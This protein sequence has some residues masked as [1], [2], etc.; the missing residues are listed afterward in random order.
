MWRWVTIGA[1]VCLAT[2]SACGEA[3]RQPPSA[4]PTAG[5]AGASSG[6]GAGSGNTGGSASAEPIPL[7]D[8]CG[9]FTRDLCVYLMECQGARYRDAAHCERELDCFGL[10]QLTAAADSGAVEYDPSKVGA[11]HARFLE[12]PCTFG[13]FLFTPDIYEVLSYC[14]GTI[15]PKLQAGEACSSNGECSTGLYCYKGVDYQCPGTCRLP[16]TEG[17][18]CA[19]SGRCADG[20]ECEADVCVA[21]PKAGD[22]CDASCDYSVSCAEGEICQ[23]NIWCDRELGQCQLGRLPGEPCGAS[24]TEP[25][26]SDA[27][28]AIHSWCDAVGTGAGVCRQPSAQGGPCNDDFSVCEDGLHCVG[29]VPFGG[30]ATLGTCQPPGPS[31]SD[32][33]GN[34]DCQSGLVCVLAK[35]AELGAEGAAC[36]GSDTC[37]AGL[38]CVSGKCASARYPGDACDGERCTYGRCVDGTC[39]HHAKVGGPCSLGTDCA[40]GHCVD[41][42]CY[43]SSVCNAPEGS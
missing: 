33:V 8:L 5:S 31:G 23:G 1:S 30:D 25:V 10:P 17:Q 43:D 27:Q 24:G 42:A 36:N 3:S 32:C 11:C 29:Y 41:G 4:Q 21:E 18:D 16:A 14:P 39:E 9:V 35:C 26:V 22:P 12:S 19:G 2:V 13:F 37:G 38:V 6:G 34:D 20:L 7:G 28:C 15:T 40:T